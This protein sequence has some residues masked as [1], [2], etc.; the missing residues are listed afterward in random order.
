MRWLAALIGFVLVSGLTGANLDVVPIDPLPARGVANETPPAP[1][2]PIPLVKANWINCSSEG[3][4]CHGIGWGEIRYG[5]G[6]RTRRITVEGDIRCSNETFGDPAPN[7]PKRCARRA[8]PAPLLPADVKPIISNFDTAALL[9]TGLTP[10]ASNKPDDVGAF[11]M[12]CT[13]GQLNYDDPILY[14]GIR[15]GSPHLH[16][17]YGNSAGRYDSSYASLRAA[18]ESSCSNKLNRAAYWVPA[19][20]TA[21]GRTVEPDY[22]ALYYKRRPDGDPQCLREAAKG[23]VGLPTGLRAVSGYDMTRMGEEQPD[24]STFHFRCI[25]PGKSSEHR[26]LLAEA[27]RDCGGV[28]QVMAAINFGPCWTGTLDSADHRSHLAWASYGTWGYLKCPATHPFVIPE[29]TQQIAYTIESGDGEVWFSSDRMNGMA[30]AGGTTF[31]ADYM[32]AWDPP[33][34]EK[35]ERFCIGKMLNC[36]DGVLGDGSMLKRPTL[37]YKATPR[38]VTFPKKWF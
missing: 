14:P 38:L 24:N 21:A 30:M 2:H 19:L 16:Q 7:T 23:C 18:G 37:T 20:M 15:G 17:W 10:P 5:T 4:V 13:A 31:H 22:I 11:R 12:I 35:F 28:G 29:L 25:T 33:T 9:V 8:V 34:R 32:E 3:K 26:H 27:I 1:P 36:S 6:D